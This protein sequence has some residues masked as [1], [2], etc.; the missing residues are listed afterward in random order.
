MIVKEAYGI[1]RR[2]TTFD[3]DPVERAD[4]F[5]NTVMEDLAK[6][7]QE[8]LEGYRQSRSFG[9]IATHEVANSEENSEIDDERT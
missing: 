7:D 5:R 8:R 9:H 6:S 4:E 2:E 1:Y 3:V